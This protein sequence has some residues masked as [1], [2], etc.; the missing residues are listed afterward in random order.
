MSL[1]QWQLSTGLACGLKLENAVGHIVL[2]FEFLSLS[3]TSARGSI[4]L[5]KCDVVVEKQL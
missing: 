1:K 5:G 3:P 2:S 4:P